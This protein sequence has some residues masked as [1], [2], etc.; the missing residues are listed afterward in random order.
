M[1]PLRFAVLGARFWAQF[2]IAAWGEVQGAELVAIYNRTRSRAE[3]TA[4]RFGIP[5]A[6]DDVEAMFASERLDFVDIVTHPSTFAYLVPLA[7]KHRLPVICQKP[8]APDLPTARE[9]VR[10]CREAGVPFFVHENWRWQPQI[11]ALKRTLEQADVGR[12][13]RARLMY[14]SNHPVFINEPH[15]RDL[16]QFILTDMGTHIL[17]VARYLFGEAHCLYCQTRRVDPTIKGEDV[18]T[19]IMEMGDGISVTCEMSYASRLE[20]QSFPQVC[21]LVECEQ[22]SVELALDYWIRTTTAAGT[23][24]TRC[25]LPWYGWMDPTHQVVHASIVSCHAHLLDALR[26]GREAETSAA[27]NLKTLELVYH[28]Y[29]S[30]AGRKVITIG[31]P[32]S[33]S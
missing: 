18:A 27:D 17:D 33:E 13:F 19:V 10:I 16:E 12:P 22:G 8:M 1:Q 31:G 25:T 23:F 11:R 15:L 21:I 4:R 9:L 7:A 2:Q 26:T 29:D 5:A 30:A 6:Y 20:H 24:A 3:E 32:Q 14:S 28:S